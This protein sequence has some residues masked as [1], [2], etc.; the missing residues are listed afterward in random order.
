MMYF[1]ASDIPA[2][3]G[4]Y[5]QKIQTKYGLRYKVTGKYFP[6]EGQ[7]YTEATFQ[8]L[9]GEWHKEGITEAR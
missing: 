8:K 3:N 2:G 5:V 4:A 6:K 7:W 9:K 1:T